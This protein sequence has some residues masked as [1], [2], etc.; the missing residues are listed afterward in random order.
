V[1][2][3]GTPHNGIH[4]AA[5]LTK[6]FTCRRASCFALLLAMACGIATVRADQEI[7]HAWPAEI[8]SGP[9][10]EAARP[11]IGQIRPVLGHL[12][13]PTTPPENKSPPFPETEPK[14][15]PSH[16]RGQTPRRLSPHTSGSAASSLRGTKPCR[17]P[18]G[19]PTTGRR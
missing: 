7:R 8:P 12:F 18:I 19:W 13:A 16:L 17:T 4:G 1:R 15:P 10:L 14:I 9:D 11:V 5:P 6:F 2:P 3:A